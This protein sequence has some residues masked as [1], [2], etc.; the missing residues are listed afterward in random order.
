M[1]IFRREKLGDRRVLHIFGLRISYRRVKTTRTLIKELRRDLEIATNLHLAAMALHPGTF[2]TFKSKHRGQDI[3]L[4][5][6][7]PSA[8][9]YSPI[10]GAIHVGVNR[11]FRM[12]Q[13]LLDYLFIQDRQYVPEDPDY[14]GE[15]DA[16]DEYIGNNC[17]KFY[18]M[19]YDF[20]PITVASVEKTKAKRFVFHDRRIAPTGITGFMDDIT[21]R[22]LNEWGS[23][24]FAALDFALWT[25]PKRIYIVGCDCS[26]NGSFDGKCQSF[27]SYDGI[28]FGWDQYKQYAQNYYP[29][30]EIIS[31]NP[32]GLKGLFTDIYMNGDSEL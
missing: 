28:R 31:V 7:G 16:A 13:I 24:I 29:D 17:K 32:V 18:G 10:D 3:V 23:V 4:L 20:L 2:G 25:H 27:D 26:I 8:N 14:M 19:H 1:E 30:V 21:I 22:P 12:P 9:R 11:A 5:G 15:Q 6:T